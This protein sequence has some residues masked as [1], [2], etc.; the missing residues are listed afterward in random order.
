MIQTRVES[1]LLGEAQ[2]P[3]D[4]LFGGQTQ[5]ALENF[6]V[7]GYRTLGSYP[8]LVQALLEI[9]HAAAL[10]NLKIGIL[11]PAQARAIAASAEQLV[12]EPRVDQFPIHALHGGGGT[13]AN[14]NANEV[15]A[16]LGEE[17]LGGQRGQYRLLHPNDHVN[18]NQSTNDVYPTAC[19]M[20]VIAQWHI[21][22]RALQHLSQVLTFKAGEY[23]DTPHLARTCFQDAIDITFGDLFWGY[24]SFV[25]RARE[26]CA[27][28]VDHLHAVNLGGTIVGRAKDVPA[29]Y[30]REI[31]LALRAVTGDN[32]FQQAAS[33]F[34]AAQNADDLAAVSTQ[35]D[36]LARGLIKIAQDL[37]ILGSG[38]EAGLGEITLPAVQPGSSIMPGKVNPVIPEFLIQLCFE[39]MGKHVTCVAGLNQ[40]ELDLNVWESSMVCSILDSMELLENGIIT[41]A[42]KCVRGVTVNVEVNARHADT[43]IPLL[44]QLV[45]EHGYS[46]ITAICKQAQGQPDQ[47]RKM[48]SMQIEGKR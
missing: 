29:A 36:L 21:F 46:K 40:G 6:P 17:K 12:R 43:L 7:R 30:M 42:D 10:T 5:R 22:D 41:F 25:N 47:I 28:A 18:L 24:A 9:K 2:V 48:L 44:T 35:L 1:D 19:H 3:V 26:R 15:L 31:I 20:A 33:L 45:H 8:E 14:M 34:D 27:D 32:A 4:A 16:N 38:P 37:R 13:S 23:Q 39:V 11:T